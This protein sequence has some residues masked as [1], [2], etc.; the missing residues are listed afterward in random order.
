MSLSY[1][2]ETMPSKPC[3]REF[4]DDHY[5]NAHVAN[6]SSR[7]VSVL[8]RR[9]RDF[10]ESNRSSSDHQSPWKR[11]KAGITEAKRDQ[12]AEPEGRRVLA[13]ARWAS[14]VLIVVSEKQEEASR[15]MFK[16]LAQLEK[17]SQLGCPSR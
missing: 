2:G 11:K 13:W 8:G 1:H 17:K 7:C 3:A 5:R 12:E 15:M 16:A 6:Q 10:R 9:F 4:S 14:I